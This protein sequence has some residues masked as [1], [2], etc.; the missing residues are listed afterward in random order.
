MSAD[1]FQASL[2]EGEYDSTKSYDIGKFIYIAFFGGII[3]TLILSLKNAKWLKADHR[4]LKII[5]VAGI[6]A[7]LIKVVI[8]G[9]SLDW[10]TSFQSISSSGSRWLMRGVSVGFFLAS[11]Y[12]LKDKYHQHLV[13]IGETEPLLKDAIIWIFIGKIIESIILFVGVFTIGFII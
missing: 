3:P 13:I 5:F 2:Q 10:V 4:V 12:L 7:L 6:A 1:I 9:V 8:L 11:N